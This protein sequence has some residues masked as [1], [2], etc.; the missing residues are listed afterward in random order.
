M[1]SWFRT[2]EEAEKLAEEKHIPSI[3][4]VI[5]DT[6]NRPQLQDTQTT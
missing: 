3:V 2:Y 1:R 6:T 4:H 5:D